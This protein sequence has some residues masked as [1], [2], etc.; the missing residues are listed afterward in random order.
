MSGSTDESTNSSQTSQSSI[1]D[2]TTDAPTR[3]RVLQSLGT[4]GV[5]AVSS[6]SG[7]LFS[8]KS[9]TV[10]VTFSSQQGRITKQQATH[11]VQTAGELRRAVGTQ[12]A[13]V[14]IPGTAVIDISD[15]FGTEIAPNVTIASN[16]GLGG[17]GGLLRSTAYINGHF[18]TESK[19]EGYIRL[20]GIRLKGP[21]T[22]VFDPRKMPNPAEH[23]YAAGFRLHPKRVI[24]DNCEVLGWTNAG[25]LIGAKEMATTSWI[26]HNQMH[27]NRMHTLGYPFELYNG[28]AMIEWNYFNRNRHS[29]TAYGYPTN[30][31]EAR[32]NFVGKHGIQH[33][34]DMHTL[35]ENDPEMDCGGR[36]LAGRICRVHHNVFL[37]MKYS[38]FSIQGY[39]VKPSAFVQNWCAQPKGGAAVGD[40]EGV[41]YFPDYGDVRVANN[42]FG[43]QAAAQGKQWLLSAANRLAGQRDNPQHAIKPLPQTALTPVHEE[44]PD[45][46]SIP[47]QDQ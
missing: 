45:H 12:G 13:V 26:H 36:D 20:S 29:I 46:N 27:H 15:E 31:Y 11:V 24:I 1:A 18:T 21:R 47:I 6:L 34:F 39:S 23:Y 43:E 10:S 2:R 28:M 35:C 5:A 38:A 40:A 7:C 32:Y 16:R 22:D 14:W 25:A 30:G 9:R 41:V 33:A 8:S 4:V 44:Q 19:G 17:T 3:R 42:Q 37:I